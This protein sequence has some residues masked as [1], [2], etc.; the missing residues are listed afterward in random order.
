MLAAEWKSRWALAPRLQV[1]G[2]SSTLREFEPRLRDA[3]AGARVLLCMAAADKWGSDW[4]SCEAEDG[5]IVEGK[6]RLR[7]GD[8]VADAVGFDL[9]DAIPRRTSGQRLRGR[10]VT[11][12][13]IPAKL[14]GSAN[15]AADIR[16]PGMVFAAIR[17]GPPG[18]SLLKSFDA[19][20]AERVRGF[21][22]VV[23]TARWVAVTAN[24]WWA[25]NMALDA[26]KPKFVTG[27]VSRDTA[28]ALAAAL[29]EDGTVIASVGDVDGLLEGAKPVVRTYSAGF[30][31]HAALEPMTATAEIKEDR[32]QLWIATQ[33]P[34][35]ARAAAARATGIAEDRITVHAMQV[36]GSFGRKYE[37]EVAAQVATIA[38]KLDRPVQLI[39]SRN[40]DIQQVRASAKGRKNNPQSQ[41]NLHL[42]VSTG[43]TGGHVR[44]PD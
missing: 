21:V 35:L 42:G 33:A 23:D 22:S 30:G 10:G 24:S 4:Q 26:M 28:K 41:R 6:N 44:R 5:F 27:G 15:Y 37:V 7:F 43:S 19:K 9:P 36:G 32:M 11:R 34:G 20:A 31:P 25:A 3:A 16:L 2:G 18:D 38:Q 8:V 29:K 14:D 17:Q 12:L 1:T 13:D 40:E 39:W